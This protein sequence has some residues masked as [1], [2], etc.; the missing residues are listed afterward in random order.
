MVRAIADKQFVEDP[1]FWHDYVFKYVNHSPTGVKDGR[2][3]TPAE[4]KEVWEAIIFLKLRCPQI[5]LRDTLTHVEKWMVQA[6]PPQLE[7]KPEKV[8]DEDATGEE[9]EQVGG[10]K[11]E[12]KIRV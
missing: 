12:K 11:E 5:D 6:K 1:V 2:K 3:F 9:T 4:A 7:E 10:D 8:S